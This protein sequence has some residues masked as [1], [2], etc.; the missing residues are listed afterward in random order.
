MKTLKKCNDVNTIDENGNFINNNEDTSKCISP[1]T[2]MIGVFERGNGEYYY[3][4]IEL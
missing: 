3:A 4:S 1:I 2:Y